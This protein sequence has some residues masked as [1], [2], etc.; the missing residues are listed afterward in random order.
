MS[1]RESLMAK[2]A[3]HL[4]VATPN[5]Y[6][7][8]PVLNSKQIHRWI[9]SITTVPI[10]IDELHVTVMYSTGDVNMSLVKPSKAF[11]LPG[12]RN[13]KLKRLGEATALILSEHEARYPKAIWQM[14]RDAGASWD[15][16]SFIAHMSISYKWE[17]DQATLDKINAYDGPISLGPYIAK[18]LEP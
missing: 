10:P 12:N 5:M 3:P 18:P 8:L 17:V 15:Y 14:F 2:L 16:P 1:F 13:R 11:V 4:E 9:A 7:E 6:A